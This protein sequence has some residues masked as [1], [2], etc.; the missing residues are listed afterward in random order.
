[1]KITVQVIATSNLTRFW[2][3]AITEDGATVTIRNIHRSEI[4]KCRNVLV[5]KLSEEYDEVI[6]EPLPS[7]RI[8]AIWKG[9]P[10]P[11]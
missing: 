11:K 3:K 7:L 6:G 1:M 9:K 4:L 10:R 2:L 5:E 8:H